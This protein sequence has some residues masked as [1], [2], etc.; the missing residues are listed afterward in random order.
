M[1]YDVKDLRLNK[2][3]RDRV[4]WAY[5]DMPVLQE[6]NKKLSRTKPFKKINIAACLHIT[7]ETAN[8]LIALKNGGANV[9]CCASN[10]LSTQDDV[11]AHLTKDYGISTFAIKGINN[12][13]YYKHLVG[14]LNIKPNITMDDGCDL[15][16]ILHKS[17]KNY[18]KDIIGGTEETTTGVIRLE[19]MSNNNVLRYPIIAVNNAFTKHLFDNRYGT[20]QSVLDS[21]MRATNRLLSG[22]TFVVCGY[23][24]CGK[25][26]AMRA[27]GLGASVIVTEIDAT[28]GLEAKMDGFQVMTAN[29]AFKKADF[30]CTVT[31]NINVIDKHHF[32]LIKNGAIISN[33]GHFNVEINIEALRKMSSKTKKIRTDIEEFTIGTKKICLLSD[34]RLVNLSAAEGHPSS[35]MDMSFANQA[36]CTEYIVKNHK[37]MENKVYDVPT[38]I[39][40][41][42]AEIKLKSMDVKIDKLSKEQDEYLN[43]WESGT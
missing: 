14:S 4:E 33:A 17:Y 2:I 15:V 38:V 32:K 43:S 41:K 3:G 5:K 30:I 27:A 19:S 28:K 18:M 31:G 25:G 39:D 24:W 36:L 20:G 11:A 22:K 37:K 40:N 7:T 29:E 9:S 34:G 21:I 23:G 13:G 16:S 35:V 1:K 42:V 8:L 10:P 26:L 6:I 12:K